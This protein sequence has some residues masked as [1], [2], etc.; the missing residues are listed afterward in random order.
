M[1]AEPVFYGES[2]HGVGGDVLSSTAQAAFTVGASAMGPE[3]VD[4]DG[5]LDGESEEEARERIMKRFERIG[6]Q[7]M[8]RTSGGGPFAE[9]PIAGVLQDPGKRSMAAQILG[10]AYVAAH[11]LML[12]NR[13]AVERIADE[14]VERKEL[15]GNE[16][17]ELLEAQD[18]R[19]P[20][21]DLL[22]EKA[23]PR[24]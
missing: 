5:K 18:L 8:N 11:N 15:Y 22:E 12:F 21:V 7:I 6:V 19:L 3:W 14:L 1:A 23:W 17:V 4:L 24:V 13:E 9:N 16:V 20:D 10:Q 2:R